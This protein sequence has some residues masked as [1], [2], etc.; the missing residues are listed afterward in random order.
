M[1]L[2]L[3]KGKLGLTLPPA[4]VKEFYEGKDGQEAPFQRMMARVS[5]MKQYSI[6]LKQREK[7]LRLEVSLNSNDG[8]IN[9][10]GLATDFL[11]SLAMHG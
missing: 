2:D 1:K 7:E 4:D 6:Q 9:R 11:E 5:S 8:L 3:A 10:I